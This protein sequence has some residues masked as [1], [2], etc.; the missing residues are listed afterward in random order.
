M[1]S[2]KVLVDAINEY[3]ENSQWFWVA[4]LAK[5]SYPILKN[6][7]DELLP[8]SREAVEHYMEEEEIKRNAFPYVLE[9]NIIK[10]TKFY[11]A[12]SAKYAKN[13]I[14]VNI[15][16]EGDFKAVTGLYASKHATRYSHREKTY[17]MSKKQFKLFQEEFNS[18]LEKRNNNIGAI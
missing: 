18:W 11:R 10:Q 13:M 7:L 1:N 17:M 3:E 15:T 16:S 14:A 12:Y 6:H 8:L 5:E 2:Y 9:S 4:G